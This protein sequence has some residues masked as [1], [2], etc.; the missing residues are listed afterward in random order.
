MLKD[1]S[2]TGEER[3]TCT[4]PPIKFDAQRRAES[5]ELQTAV[6][7]L[8][9]FLEQ[10]EAELELR[11]RARRDVDRC[12]FHLAIQVI[13][14]NLAALNLVNP[15]R[16]LAV[17]RNSGMM[18]SESRY[19]EPVY[20]QHFLD[21]LDLMA[22]PKV[23]LT[24]TL[25][26]GFRINRSHKRSSTIEPTAALATFV[27]PTLIKWEALSRA[28]VPEVLILKGP[29][30]RKSGRSD[31]IDYKD[32][33]TTRRRRKEILKINAVLR[34]A[35]IILMT[36]DRATMGLGDDDQ[37][38]DPTCRSVR[39]IFNN[40]TWYE[41]GRLFD[42][43]WETM[44]RSDRFKFLRIRTEAYPDGEAIANVDF[45]QLFPTLAYHRE[46]YSV[47]D[48]DLYDII[49]GGV[50]REGWKKLINALLFADGPMT[51][52]PKET[53]SLFVKGTKLRDALGVVKHFHAPI[54]H[55]FGTS[56]GFKL[57]LVE[58]EILIQALARF[59]QRR[60][61]ALPLHDSVLVAASHAEDAKGIMAEAFGVFAE[62]ARAKLKIDFC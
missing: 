19:H 18:W 41:G 56:V 60:I 49:G 27:P 14:C 39:R 37:P 25:T 44:P 51:R 21:A 17:P 35:P 24:N 9:A 31:I 20:G 54:A 11:K 22:H 30:D 12:K 26:H 52:W 13:V 47:P 15:S 36:D 50:S 4:L 10:R 8:I 5:V 48:G 43:F 2:T 38:I 55:L 46:G 16:P 62:D 6:K 40:G 45:G 7:F 61:T 58:S 42:G 32:T 57:M 34:A 53:S 23:G 1:L 33:A 3:M 29:K 59:A 28:D